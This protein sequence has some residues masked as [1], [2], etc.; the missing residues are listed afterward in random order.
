MSSPS[1]A[2]PRL[3]PAPSAHGNLEWTG[4][5]RWVARRPLTAFLV[6]SLGYAALSRRSASACW[7]TSSLRSRREPRCKRAN[8]LPLAGPGL[9]GSSQVQVDVGVDDT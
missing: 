5:R 8:S 7:C 3:Y 1:T 2:Q 4:L 9:T 6:T